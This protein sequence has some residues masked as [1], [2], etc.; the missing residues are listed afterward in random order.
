MIVKKLVLFL[1]K[2]IVFILALA[3]PILLLM[4]LNAPFSKE[5]LQAIQLVIFFIPSMKQISPLLFI[6]SILVV[7]L[8][9]MAPV[10]FLYYFFLLASFSSLMDSFLKL[11]K[12]SPL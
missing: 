8:V 3:W 5:V 7:L 6:G 12:N 4:L 9:F 2:F 1:I 10:I 11:R